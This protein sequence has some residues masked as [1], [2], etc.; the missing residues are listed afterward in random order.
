MEK[1]LQQIIKEIKETCIPKPSNEIS[2]CSNGVQLEEED[3][4]HVAHGY[5]SCR[6]QI[7]SNLEN[8]EKSEG[9]N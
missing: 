2:I 7:I 4:R 1:D 6:K 8:Y 9:D 3:F 5:D